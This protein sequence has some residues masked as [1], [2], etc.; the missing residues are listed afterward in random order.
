MNAR[1]ISAIFAAAAL[2]SSI[3]CA[4]LTASAAG[5][6]QL[7]EASGNVKTGKIRFDASPWYS[8][9]DL[10][11]G[12]YK[13]K[14]ICFYIWD[15]TT[16]PTSFASQNGWSENNTWGSKKLCGTVVE[17]EPGVFE[18]YEIEIPDDHAI[19]VIFYNRNTEAQTY[20]CVLT[21]DAFGDTAKLTGNMLE[22]PIDSQY[23]AAEVVFENC[24]LTAPLMI[25]S[26]GKI[27]GSSI[28]VNMNRP[29]K[30]AE[31]VAKYLGTADKATGKLRAT[32]EIVAEAVEKFGTTADEVWEEYQNLPAEKYTFYDLDVAK[33]V[34]CP[35]DYKVPAANICNGGHQY[36]YMGMHWD[37]E[38][39][40]VVNSDTDTSS[41]IKMENSRQRRLTADALFVCENDPAHME[42]V[43]ADVT[44]PVETKK[45]LCEENGE[46][47]S[48]A[49]VTFEGQKYSDKKSERV[50][51]TGHEYNEPQWRWN[52]MEDVDALFTCKNDGKKKMMKADV[53]SEKD[54]ETGN[55]VFTAAVRIHYEDP[56]VDSDGNVLSR[57]V[58]RKAINP[59]EPYDS[60]AEDTYLIKYEFTEYDENGNETKIPQSYYGWSVKYTDTRV[61][62]P[63]GNDITPDTDVDHYFD[64]DDEKQPEPDTDTSTKTDPCADGHK[65]KF[66][67]FEWGN[68]TESAKAK[69]VCENDKSHTTDVDATITHNITK[70]STCEENGVEEIIT[71][72]EFEGKTYSDKRETATKTKG[73]DFEEK[74]DW[75]VNEDGSLKVLEVKLT[76]TCKND[77]SHKYTV[78]ASIMD[79]AVSDDKTSVNYIAQAEYDGVLYEDSASFKNIDSDN[80]SDKPKPI[81][82]STPDT[83]EPKPEPDH[84]PDTPEPKPEP[85]QTPDTPEPKPEPGQTPDTPDT[86]DPKPE[87]DP[88]PVVMKGDVDFDEAITSADALMV[89]RV[90][91]LLDQFEENETKAADVDEDG[92]I[93]SSDAIKILRVATGLDEF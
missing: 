54:E 11:N 6:N 68:N 70:E 25:T 49:T 71:S 22:N 55:T 83:P 30:V 67:G 41:G 77:P 73:H 72:A 93:T 21:A 53:T 8:E 13:S 3:A 91:A 33:A 28:P 50:V 17:D 16:E 78:S 20:D 85:G 37:S 63:D 45:A 19:C 10:K 12:N 76:L 34:I 61:I 86:P 65:Y 5:T 59:G 26:T 42:V 32:R 88:E 89:L 15:E 38:Y 66:D 60:E 48:T 81:T 39:V 44:D 74:W 14:D 57:G 46:K 75:P 4:P 58:A 84:T 64:S 24:G 47:E 69:F 18:S 9:E 52:S 2:L 23:T 62:D 79:S 40:D 31:Y 36:K 51:R 27:Q 29:R 92:S 1:K 90:S 82:D 56:E 80:D 43:K 7:P 35:S 87:P